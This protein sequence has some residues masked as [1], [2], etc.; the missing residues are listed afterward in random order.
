MRSRKGPI[1]AS[2]TLVTGLAL[3]SAKDQRGDDAEGPSALASSVSAPVIVDADV[4]K[5]Q[6][7]R[8]LLTSL[9]PAHRMKHLWLVHRVTSMSL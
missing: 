4:F 5:R 9:D 3:P 1:A 6:W 2:C 8:W 7:G